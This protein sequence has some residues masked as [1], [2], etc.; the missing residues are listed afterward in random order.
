MCNSKGLTEGFGFQLWT[1]A[2][3]HP[4]FNTDLDSVR[5]GTRENWVLFVSAVNC[6]CAHVK[7]YFLRLNVG[8]AKLWF[9]S[10]HYY[11]CTL[12]GGALPVSCGSCLGDALQ[13]KLGGERDLEAVWHGQWTCGFFCWFEGKIWPL[14]FFLCRV[15]GNCQ[16]KNSDTKHLVIFSRVYKISNVK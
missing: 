4:V 13:A 5:K 3:R 6:R 10:T 2:V 12:V 8:K 14:P 11:C 7:T 16:S 15:E 9:V 1:F